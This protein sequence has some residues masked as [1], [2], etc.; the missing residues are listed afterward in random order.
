MEIVLDALRLVARKV[1]QDQN[2][3]LDG[4]TLLKIA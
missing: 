3:L 4:D 2:G 1:I